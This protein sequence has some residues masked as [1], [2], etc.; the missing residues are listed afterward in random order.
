[1]THY[2][3]TFSKSLLSSDGHQFK[4]PQ[5]V[6]DL[7]ALDAEVALQTAKRRFEGLLRI[8][9]WRMRADFI[10]V[11]AHQLTDEID[12]YGSLCFRCPA[13]DGKL[14]SGIDTD[15]LT[16]SRIRTLD[17]RADCPICHHSHLWRVMDGTLGR[18][19]H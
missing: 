17:V 8:R 3:V 15:A 1:M 6:I 19:A 18:I 10:D 2:Q 11:S 16:L 12:I 13:S 9:N 4:C 14:Y 7:D 5:R